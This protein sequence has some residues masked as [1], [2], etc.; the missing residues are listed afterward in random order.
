MSW[1]ISQSS[2]LSKLYR[3]VPT[4]WRHARQ[5]DNARHWT[6]VTFGKS[7]HARGFSAN[8]KPVTAVI[9]QHLI[10]LPSLL[11]DFY[12]YDFPLLRVFP[13]ESAGCLPFPCKTLL[14]TWQ[15]QTEMTAVILINH[16]FFQLRWIIL[17][18]GQWSMLIWSIHPT[19]FDSH[20]P[21]CDI[22]KVR[23][24]FKGFNTKAVASIPYAV[25]QTALKLSPNE[26]NCV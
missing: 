7:Y 8:F 4:E 19:P 16:S 15:C 3:V 22:T 21:N 12:K 9:P 1:L 13:R 2:A 5:G 23:Q 24:T 10:P 20:I 26:L 11:R 14:Q 6:G 17:S 18:V 25:L